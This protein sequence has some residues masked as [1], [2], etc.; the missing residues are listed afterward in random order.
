MSKKISF[1]SCK[2]LTRELFKAMNFRVDADQHEQVL[3]PAKPSHFADFLIAYLKKGGR[4]SHVYDYDFV[5]QDF[6]YTDWP[7]KVH[8]NTIA[9][10]SKNIIAE[11]EQMVKRVDNAARGM[12]YGKDYF[13]KD[14]SVSCKSSRPFIPLY[15]DVADVMEK[16]G[17]V[18]K[19]G[20]FDCTPF[21]RC[22][23]ELVLS[24]EE[25]FL[26]DAVRSDL[27]LQIALKRARFDDEKELRYEKL[28]KV[29]DKFRMR[30]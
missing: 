20:Q 22:D 10:E 17:W 23:Q 29:R 19:M 8:K 25:V 11:D 4:V 28:K 14:A 13:L 6:F 9:T 1:R 5:G 12:D 30:Y 21:T 27:K 16:K 2:K 24:A 3:Q 18:F 15:I 7:I 26:L